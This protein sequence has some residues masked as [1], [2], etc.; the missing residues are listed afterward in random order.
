MQTR[1]LSG[2]SDECGPVA[3]SVAGC[4]GEGGRDGRMGI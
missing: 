1:P 3:L 2:H 4:L